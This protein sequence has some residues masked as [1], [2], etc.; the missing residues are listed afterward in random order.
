[1]T[2]AVESLLRA[3]SAM[4]TTTPT[5]PEVVSLADVEDLPGSLADA[6][7]EGLIDVIEDLGP[8]TL[9][10]MSTLGA[11]RIGVV[12]TFDSRRW[13]DARTGKLIGPDDPRYLYRRRR[14][15]DPED[16]FPLH[17]RVDEKQLRPEDLFVEPNRPYSSDRP[18]AIHRFYG[19]GAVWKG[20]ETIPAPA[21]CPYCNGARIGI[22]AYCL[23]C[24]NSGMDRFL[25]KPKASRRRQMPRGKSK[26]KG[27]V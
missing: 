9:F 5:L 17:H 27:G 19:M 21:S 8:E 15:V 13:K 10:V 26:L 7:A 12:P 1:M 2:E 18:P 24:H 20:E 25:E 3:M 16:E 22:H 23:K 14:E 6:I 11:E 4:T